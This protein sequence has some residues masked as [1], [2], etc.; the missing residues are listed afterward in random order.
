MEG[1]GKRQDAKWE[2]KRRRE[3]RKLVEFVG[4]WEGR[5]NSEQKGKVLLRK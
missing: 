4:Y 5:E 2:K 1:G 3:S